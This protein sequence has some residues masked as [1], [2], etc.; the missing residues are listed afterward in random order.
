MLS[1]FSAQRLAEKKEKTPAVMRGFFYAALAGE[2]R[3]GTGKKK[4]RAESG[5]TKNEPFLA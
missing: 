4:G 3:R 2:A 5:E 1:A